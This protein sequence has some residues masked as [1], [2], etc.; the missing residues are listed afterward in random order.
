MSLFYTSDKWY[1][2][3]L[4]GAFKSKSGFIGV[5]KTQ[6]NDFKPHISL[7]GSTVFFP[8]FN[9]AI[10]AALF[11]DEKR[12]E[13]LGND[14]ITNQSAGLIYGD[15]TVKNMKKVIDEY[16]KA[17]KLGIRLANV[18]TVFLEVLWSNR[19]RQG[20]IIDAEKSFK[21]RKCGAIHLTDDETKLIL[22]D[23]Q[24][25]GLIRITSNKYGPKLWVAKLD[26]K[27]EL[28]PTSP[29]TPTTKEKDMQQ[30]DKLSPEM[31]EN[32]AKQA[33]E[34]ARAKK[35]EAEE[36]HNLRT[37]L[38]PLILNA[39]QAKGKYERLLNELLDTSTELDNV[40]NALKD[41]LK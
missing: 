7:N 4:R 15:Y 1:S 40:L 9:D 27:K 18:A 25:F 22:N 24:E 23:L 13:L 41:A 37:L 32:L 31:L 10:S 16:I 8:S 17:N 12:V 30:L 34:L 19:T 38:D 11:I 36:K 26:L 39:V 35:Q 2:Y 6:N 21:N 20:R 14:C 3:L 29:I 33:A 5:I 28:R